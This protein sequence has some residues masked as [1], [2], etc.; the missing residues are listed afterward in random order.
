MSEGNILKSRYLP[1]NKYNK[2]I[3]EELRSQI[4]SEREESK[5]QVG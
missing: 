4:E 2:Y 5:W 1:N 3:K